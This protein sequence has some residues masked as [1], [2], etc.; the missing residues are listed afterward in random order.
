MKIIIILCPK[1]WKKVPFLN[2]FID[3]DNIKAKIFC[4]CLEN[5]NYYIL[6]LVEYL[7][8]INNRKITSK[9]SIHPESNATNF[10]MNCENWLCQIC[11]SNHTNSTYKSE[12][13]KNSIQKINCEKHN[14]KKRY[15]FLNNGE[16]L[17]CKECFLR[18]NIRNKVPHK[19]V[20]IEHYNTKVKMKSKTNKYNEY[21][22]EVIELDNNFK[23]DILLNIN[24]M[25]N[26]NTNINNA[27][28]KNKINEEDLIK[29]K[30]IIQKYLIHKNINEQ[31][32]YLIEIILK[33]YEYFNDESIINKNFICNIIINTGIK[34]KYPK[35]NKEILLLDQINNFIN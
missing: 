22:Q 12:Y 24:S 28:N 2:T 33:N 35:L 29:Y 6:E 25:Q 27:D 15:I 21:Q 26:N 3:G 13:R 23:T 10:F 8:L 14:Q 9:C 7:S 31:L 20:N 34:V 17:F 11:L 5:N 1:F 30:N 18:H 19:G 32:K 16:F 4:T